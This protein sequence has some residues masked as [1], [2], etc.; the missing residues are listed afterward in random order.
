MI[1]KLDRTSDVILSLLNTL[2]LWAVKCIF[3]QILAVMEH[4][5]VTLVR[6]LHQHVN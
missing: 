1:Q 4:C 5:T 2:L 6:L 3:I